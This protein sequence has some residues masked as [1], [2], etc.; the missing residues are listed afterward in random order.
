VCG[1]ILT[2]YRQYLANFA[3][4]QS[5]TRDWIKATCQDTVIRKS[6]AGRV[7]A[8]PPANSRS[9]KYFRYQPRSVT[10]RPT[11][12]IFGRRLLQVDRCLPKHQLNSAAR[13]QHVSSWLTIASVSTGNASSGAWPTTRVSRTFSS[14]GAWSSATASTT[15]GAL[16]CSG[17]LSATLGSA[18]IPATFAH[19]L[20][21]IY[22]QRLGSPPRRHKKR[23]GV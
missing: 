23:G 7:A 2:H 17:V 3:F 5:R 16:T 10:K 11:I 20:L 13:R 8:S 9:N 22:Q 14:P 21:Q 15:Q 1:Q 6:A 12:R 4:E 19:S 18:L